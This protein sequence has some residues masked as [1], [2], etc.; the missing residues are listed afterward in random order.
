VRKYRNI[1]VVEAE[2]MYLHAYLIHVEDPRRNVNAD[3]PGYIYRHIEGPLALRL[4][5]QRLWM[6]KAQ[7]EALY[8]TDTGR[9]RQENK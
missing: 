1:T 3:K 7:F 6:G 8:H 2:P 9:N 5:H 4:R